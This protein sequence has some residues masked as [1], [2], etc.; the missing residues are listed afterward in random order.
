MNRLA[1]CFLW[2]TLLSPA[3]FAQNRQVMISV[4]WT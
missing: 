1:R 3:A 4:R 2:L